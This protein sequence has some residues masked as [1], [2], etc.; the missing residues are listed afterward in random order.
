MWFI[1]LAGVAGLMYFFS[2]TAAGGE[3]IQATEDSVAPEL[4]DW[5][6]FDVLFQQ[7]GASHGVDWQWLKAFALNESNLGRDKSVALGIEHP[8]DIENSK[9]SDGKSWGLMQM[10]IKTARGLDSSATEEKLN[11]PDFSIDLSARY[12]AQLMGMFSSSDERYVEWVVKSYNQGPGNTKKEMK[13]GVSY[14]QEYW[15]RWLRNYNR[16]GA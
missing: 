9:S 1:A 7:Y 8:S 10:T 13:T 12:I 14:A 2:Q 6:R 15:D 4:T 11:D 5:N 16:V 3:Y